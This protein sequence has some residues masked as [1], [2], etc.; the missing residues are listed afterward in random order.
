M[1]PIRV[2][3]LQ[4]VGPQDIP[5]RRACSAIQEETANNRSRFRLWYLP[6]LRVFVVQHWRT[7]AE[8]PDQSQV[9]ES[10]IAQWWTDDDLVAAAQAPKGTSKRG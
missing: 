2:T 1:S 7:G 9:P 10:R 4:F 6:R 3:K 8:S 5:G